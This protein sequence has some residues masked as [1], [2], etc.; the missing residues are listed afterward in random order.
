MKRK[1]TSWVHYFVRLL[2]HDLHG[3]ATH[4]DYKWGVDTVP[5]R[6]LVKLK[7]LLAIPE[8][9]FQHLTTEQQRVMEEVWCDGEHFAAVSP[10]GAL[11][12]CMGEDL[13]C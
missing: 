7:H 10:Q 13:M 3:D 2:P 8:W 4:D 6:M 5:K 12:V 9:D 11:R 1:W